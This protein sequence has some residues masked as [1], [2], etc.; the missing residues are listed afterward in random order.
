MANPFETYRSQRAASWTRVD[1]V[2]ALYD[3]A[4]SRIGQALEAL[5]RSEPV[6][7]RQ[8]CLRILQVIA[9]LR[10]GVDADA[11]SLPQDILRLYNFIDRCITGGTREDLEVARKIITPI[12]DSFQEIRDN[13]AELEQIGEIPPL[14]FE[15]E[16]GCI[17]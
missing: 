5:D 9:C 14:R 3:E 1:M 4:I 11:G 17:A 2:L 8:H 15:H 13:V 7:S 12:R 10:S 6:V 16:S